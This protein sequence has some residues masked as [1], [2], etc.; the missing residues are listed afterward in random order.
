MNSGLEEF[1]FAVE[2]SETVM[3]F[4]LAR[5]TARNL[6]KYH[7]FTRALLSKESRHLDMALLARDVERRCAIILC[8][9]EP[10]KRA[11]LWLGHQI[12]EQRKV[13]VLGADVEGTAEKILKCAKI[14]QNIPQICQN[15]VKISYLVPNV[16]SVRSAVRCSPSLTRVLT[17]AV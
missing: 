10:A 12:L 3:L 8:P 2:T 1:E 17:T 6:R 9:V 5:R 11:H 15:I 7:Y 16:F 4:G 14:P 13:S